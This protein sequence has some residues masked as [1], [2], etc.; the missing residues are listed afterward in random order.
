MRILERKGVADLDF[1]FGKNA[2]TFDIEPAGTGPS[3]ALW[4]DRILKMDFAH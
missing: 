3:W 2:V 4:S 1:A